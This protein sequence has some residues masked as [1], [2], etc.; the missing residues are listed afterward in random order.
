MGESRKHRGDGDPPV[1]TEGSEGLGIAL[2][3]VL[4]SLGLG[5]TPRSMRGVAVVQENWKA[6]S[7]VG[8]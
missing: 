8:F 2:R 6:L 5:L 4:P 7:F 1:G 3:A